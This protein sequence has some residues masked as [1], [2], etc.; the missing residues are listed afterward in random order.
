MTTPP[1][2][3]PPYDEQL[4]SFLRQSV[5]DFQWM[6][7]AGTRPRP[8]DPESLVKHL[9]RALSGR[10]AVVFRA[11]HHGFPVGRYKTRAAAQAHIEHLLI[12]DGGESVRERIVWSAPP[13]EDEAVPVWDVSLR[14]AAGSPVPTGH[15]VLAIP[16][17]AEFVPDTDPIPVPVPFVLTEYAGAV[18]AGKDTR[19]SGESTPPAPAQVFLVGHI[20][21]EIPVQYGT[22]A[23]A[24]AHAETAASAAYPDTTA[25]LWNWVG[26]DGGLSELVSTADGG[27]E[28][29]TGYV[30]V[31]K[32]HTDSEPGRDGAW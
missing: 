32:T 9:A 4:L 30:V 2:A 13:S 21:D 5:A 1:T 23:E 20:A 24:R 28:R 29:S 8:L 15:M 17:D 14:N 3:T 11:E 26:C 7:G 10:P 27:P 25:V 18:L 16:V 12:R 22:E 31:T 6:P 19:A